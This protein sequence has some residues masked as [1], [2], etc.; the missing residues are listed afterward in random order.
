MYIYIYLYIYTYMYK[1]THMF[2]VKWPLCH[3]TV[4][5]LPCQTKNWMW[6]VGSRILVLTSLIHLQV[7]SPTATMIPSFG[8]FFCIFEWINPKDAPRHI[9]AFVGDYE[10]CLF[11]FFH[12]PDTLWLFFGFRPQNL[13]HLRRAG[14]GVFWE[15][16][17][18]FERSGA[19]GHHAVGH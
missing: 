15:N 6:A 11:L 10:T 5:L 17:Q 9:S 14:E 8:F 1:H 18:P 7:F 13:P 12:S 19:V 2:D 4:V 3:D 16:V